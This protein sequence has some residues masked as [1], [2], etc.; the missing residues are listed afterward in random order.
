MNFQH[1]FK[2]VSKLEHSKCGGFLYI[3]ERLPTN[4]YVLSLF[5]TQTQ[6]LLKQWPEPVYVKQLWPYIHFPE[7]ST[8]DK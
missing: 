3:L 6:K 1:Q 2:N 8:K 4:T 7:S 5:E